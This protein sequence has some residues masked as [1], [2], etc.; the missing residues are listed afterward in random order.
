MDIAKQ[1]AV[2]PA[3]AHQLMTVAQCSCKFS[4]QLQILSAVADSQSA[5]SHVF[6]DLLRL[7]IANFRFSSGYD[8]LD[9]PVVH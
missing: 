6:S 7:H 8:P 5:A 9:D 3:R 4:V 2:H 1:N